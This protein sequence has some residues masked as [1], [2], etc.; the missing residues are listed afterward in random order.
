MRTP[1]FSANEIVK[2]LIEIEWAALGNETPPPIQ[3]VEPVEEL[4]KWIALAKNIT[5]YPT[6][7]LADPEP[8]AWYEKAL[9]RIERCCQ[10]HSER[11][12]STMAEGY[13]IT[14]AKG[15]IISEDSYPT[16][17]EAAGLRLIVTILMRSLLSGGP[18]AS[19]DPERTLKYLHDFYQECAQYDDTLLHPLAPII[20]AWQLEKSAKPI[21]EEYEKKH[22]GGILPPKS[23]AL[24]RDIWV[25]S[26]VTEFTTTP[27]EVGQ[28]LL[29]SLDTP[30]LLPSV[31]TVEVAPG[32]KIESRSGLLSIPIRMF[33]EAVMSART[34]TTR[35]RILQETPG[36]RQGSGGIRQGRLHPT[37][38]FTQNRERHPPI[39]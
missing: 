32:V 8:E 38:Q 26:P 25:E 39:G 37:A 5:E 35:R 10:T 30:A 31:L 9:H 15:D 4:R 17:A 29:P 19:I 33:Y 27:P 1:T 13:M 2:R 28:L 16:N 18:E 24:V 21:T 14:N 23:A 36:S 20:K 3:T 11:L 12:P 22:P 7:P 34:Q 6:P